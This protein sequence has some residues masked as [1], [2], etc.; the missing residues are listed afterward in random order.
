MVQDL[1]L[2]GFEREPSKGGHGRGPLYHATD[3]EAHCSLKG[4][5]PAVVR[6][7]WRLQVHVCFSIGGCCIA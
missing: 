6:H 4:M 7:F 5:L 3:R 2:G 1:I